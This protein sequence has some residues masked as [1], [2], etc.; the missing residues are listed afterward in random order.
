MPSYQILVSTDDCPLTTQQ[1]ERAGPAT[2]LLPAS[3]SAKLTFIVI[4]Q[5]LQNLQFSWMWNYLIL[6]GSLA[7]SGKNG[8]LIVSVRL[9]AAF[10]R[11]SLSKKLIFHTT[12][13]SK[14]AGKKVNKTSGW[15]P[16][17]NVKWRWFF[18]RLDLHIS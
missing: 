6:L 4:P 3:S 18:Y 5:K 16:P 2:K 11:D 7:T 8:T 12:V 14:Y 1:K 17:I 9:S 13:L 15:V 10:L